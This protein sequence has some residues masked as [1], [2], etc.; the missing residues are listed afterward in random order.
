LSP[1]CLRAIHDGLG[2]LIKEKPQDAIN[3][4]LVTHLDDGGLAILQYVNDT[5][6]LI[7][8]YLAIGSNM[9]LSWAILNKFLG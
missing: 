3:L 7:E 6:L 4:V 5:I 2:M 9:K 1:F 8:D